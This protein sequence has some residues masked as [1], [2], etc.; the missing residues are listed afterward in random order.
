LRL[1]R[2]PILSFMSRLIDLSGQ[3]F[4]RLNVLYKK[5]KTGPGHAIWCCLCE[6]GQICFIDSVNLRKGLTKSCGCLQRELVSDRKTEHG[7]SKR[8]HQTSEYNSW[9]SM[10]ERCLNPNSPA[11]EL[12]GGRGIKVCDKWLTFEGFIEDMGL[13]PTPKHSLDRYPDQ[14]GDYELS[15]CRWATMK[16]Q[17]INRTN[18]RWIEYN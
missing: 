9:A 15:N 3:Q 18:N 11:Y 4:G 5:E 16:Q 13:K 1:L 17:Q 6:C 7:H 2:H 8:G 12:Y 10:K 14:N